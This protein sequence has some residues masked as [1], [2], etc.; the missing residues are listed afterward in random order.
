MMCADQRPALSIGDIHVWAA[1]LVDDDET[2]ADLLTMLDEGERARAAQFAFERDRA[3][4]IQSH[5]M[6]RQILSE[7][8]EA[9][10]ATLTFTRNGHGKPF[11]VSPPDSPNLQF[12]LSHSGDFCM[13]AVRQDRAI[14]IDV[15]EIR[16]LPQAIA[17]AQSYFTPAES[18]MLAGLQETARRDAFFALW[19]HKEALVKGLGVGMAANLAHIEFDVDPAS[20]LRLIGCDG[21]HSIAQEWSI[22]RIDPAPNYVGAIA[23]VYPVGSLTWHDWHYTVAR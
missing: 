19:T 10:P 20:G 14:G 8:S 21:D 23:S 1:R 12:S 9:D 6:M 16:D 4:F 13:L 11:L 2:I 5:A 22:L 17:I 7:Y 15:E 18:R 3:R